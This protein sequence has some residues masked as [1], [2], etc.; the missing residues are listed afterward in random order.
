MR[1]FRIPA[2]C[3]P[4][5][6][7]VDFPSLSPEYKLQSRATVMTK[8]EKPAETE[9]PAHKV[10]QGRRAM[11]VLVAVSMAF[12]LVLAA[13]ELGFRAY[14]AFVYR[15]SLE[16][17][18]ASIPG[19]V[20]AQIELGDF[21][22]PVD[23]D[24]LIY[25]LKPGTRG[26]FKGA[27]VKLNSRG[28]RDDEIEAIK[29]AN[30]LRILALGDSNAFAW[31]VEADDGF[32]EVLQTSMQRLHGDRRG[33][34]VINTAAP[35][36]N[37]IMEVE[38]FLR[39]GPEL[40]PDAVLMQY[41]F[42]DHVVPDFV[43]ERPYF[44]R[45]DRLFIMEPALMFG[46]QWKTDEAEGARL[47]EIDAPYQPSEIAPGTREME[48]IPEQYRHHAGTRG[49]EDAYKRLRDECAKLAIPLFVVLPAEVAFEWDPNTTGD[50]RY[51]Q[52]KSICAHLEI[53]VIDTFG[54]T[55]AFVIEHG[56]KSSDLAVNI[57]QGDWH[58]GV[59]R[60]NLMAQAVLP[61]LL[62]ALPG[63]AEAGLGID[64]ELR[65]LNDENLAR[66]DEIRSGGR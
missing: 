39:D 40:K 63:G 21:I 64:E 26:V 27:H 45:W 34:E 53:T 9:A 4:G 43:K 15:G 22:R 32:L 59:T 37:A 51:D 2:R 65:R 35:G 66:L 29:P 13:T 3:A 24:N 57:A 19:D 42:N 55:H 17:L 62:S 54:V 60:H 18:S 46:G 33:I 12:V 47:H 44:R 50:P 5:G 14:L 38:I 31:G 20:N 28:Y 1:R 11:F 7:R 48:E 52:I 41:S 36:Y 30:E 23:N 16:N 49:L 6:L 25:R 61:Q 56:L 10:S 58:P 8:P